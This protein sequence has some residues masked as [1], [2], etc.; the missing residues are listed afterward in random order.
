MGLETN[1]TNDGGVP[2]YDMVKRW[3]SGNTT[4]WMN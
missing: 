2:G 1:I 3:R 4:A